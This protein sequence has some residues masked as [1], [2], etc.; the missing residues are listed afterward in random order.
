MNLIT[1]RIALAGVLAA[2]MSPAAATTFE[3]V[4]AWIAAPSP[5]V[6]PDAGRTLGAQDAALIASLLPPGYAQEYQYP[7]VKMEIQATGPIP[8]HESYLAATQQFAGTA[9]IAADGTLQN[10]TAGRPFSAEQ[11][12]AATP[13]Q[14]GLMLAWNRIYR[15]QYFG[16]RN[17][18]LTMNYIKPVVAGGRGTLHEG[19]LGGGHIERFVVQNYQRVYLNHLAWLGS[20]S[21]RADADDATSRLYK[22]YVEF[23]EPFDVKGTKFVVERPLDATE[24]DQVNSYLPSQRRVRRLSAQ[25]RAD[26]YMGTDMTMDDFEGFSGRVL[27]FDWKLLGEKDVMGVVDSVAPLPTFTGPQSRVPL[28]RWQV[29]RC[30]VVEGRPKWSGHPYSRKIFFFDKETM[31][32]SV[33]LAFNRQD[34]LW[35]MFGVIYYRPTP[36]NATPATAMETSVPR[37]SA[38]FAI[39]SLANTSTVSRADKPTTNPSMNKQQIKRRFDVSSLTEGR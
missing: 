4:L 14:A 13:A 24:E 11:V 15:W 33:A 20:N 26:A 29:R 3:D 37:W 8:P 34:E 36:D 31:G 28:D 5:A 16:W 17:D 35:R 32:S 27:D 22:D 21:Y 23:L 10:F 39:D 38:T 9:S 25:E 30:Y 18:E 2:L 7:D 12:A 1:K 19:M 6:L